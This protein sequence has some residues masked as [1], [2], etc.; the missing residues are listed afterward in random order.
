MKPRLPVALL[1]LLLVATGC[2]TGGCSALGP[3]S[4]G[5]SAPSAFPRPTAGEFSVMTFNLHQYALQPGADGAESSAPAP[6]PGADALVDILRQVAPDVLA[7]QEM[8]DALAWADFKFRLRQAGLDYRYEEYLPREGQ[9]LHLAVLSRL[10]IVAR[11]PRTEDLYTIGPKQFPVLRGFI[12]LEI[13]AHP[14]YRFRLLAAH[15][16]SKQFH[17]YGQA[18]MR[19]NEARLLNNHVRAILKDDPAA[20]LLVLGTLNDDPASRVLREIHSYQDKPLLFDLRPVDSAG[21]AWT[22]RAD[23]DTHQ[24]TDYLL[25]N[26][27]MLNEVRLDKTYVVRSPRLLDASNHR[28]LVATFTAREQAAAPDLAARRPPVFSEND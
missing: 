10:P 16:K 18:E 7:V 27:G 25:V 15:L 6:R 26:A 21:D 20:N 23:D 5:L 19:R 4:G 2:G 14:D 28:P 24:R 11:N 13:E 22:F 17:P 9:S 12:E 1:V 8:G 3:D